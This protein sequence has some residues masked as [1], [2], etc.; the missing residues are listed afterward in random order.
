MLSLKIEWANDNISRVELHPHGRLF[1]GHPE[2]QKWIDAYL[3]L[4]PIPFPLP[5]DLSGL[6]PFTQKVLLEIQKIP[7]GQT[8]TYKEVAEAIGNPKAQRAVGGACGRNPYPL[9]IPCHRV[10]G[11]KDL[12]GFS[13][14]SNI[15]VLLY[16]LECQ[17]LN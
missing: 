14:N 4:E 6:T 7:F 3:N 8:K 5:L 9:F 1:S 15:K 11:S 12:G 13:C 17:K 2:I 10:V 16:T